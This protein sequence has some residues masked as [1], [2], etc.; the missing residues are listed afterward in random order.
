MRIVCGVACLAWLLVL[1]SPASVWADG[2]KKGLAGKSAQELVSDLGSDS[3]K[4]REAAEAELVRRGAGAAKAL[5]EA[6][7]E[8]SLG[9]EAAQRAQEILAKVDVPE[10]GAVWRE[11]SE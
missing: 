3:Y 9:P 11:W 1:A 5:R 8:G 4:D 6:I 10:C 7:N 2:G